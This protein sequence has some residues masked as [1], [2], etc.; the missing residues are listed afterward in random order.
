MSR[1]LSY[2]CASICALHL[3]CLTAEEL[4]I[5]QEI[6]PTESAIDLPM[7]QAA[8]APLAKP[9]PVPEQ[10]AVVVAE[11]PVAQVKPAAP[12]RP[13]TGKVKGKKVRLRL[14][15]DLESS[16]VKELNKS[17]LISVV[18]E[19]GN[20]WA[21]EPPA[22]VKAYVFRSFVLDNV[23]EGNR[24]NVRLE[25]SLDAPV[26]SHLSS[27]DKVQGAVSS[28]NNKWLEIK[29]PSA[30]RFYVA[31]D[32]VQ[33]VGGPELKA[34]LDKKRT[35][36]SHLFESASHLAKTEMSRPFEEIDLDKIKHQF[37]VIISDYSDFPDFVD[38][39]K[40]AVNQLQETYLQRRI[41]FLE[42]K[43]QKTSQMEEQASIAE[44]A[45]AAAKEEMAIVT[46]KMRMWEPIEE[47]L[48]LSWA[49]VNENK[50]MDEFYSEAKLTAVPLTGIL[51]SYVT[52]VKNKPGDFILKDKELP[53]AYLYS[54]HVNLHNL[55]GKKVTLVASPRPNN[56][57]AFPAYVVLGVESKSK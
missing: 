32:L 14:N 34:Q 36:V 54:T 12:F 28:L 57:F 16:V 4:T 23:V 22:D 11:K 52:P 3:T 15:A 41:A 8:P 7:P 26:I 45:A 6:I 55:V 51:E 24:V 17:D 47:A 25:P 53:V 33:S 44:A 38:K 13:F 56:N 18:G 9:S 19:T 46:D 2:F 5:P 30:T 48:Y 27:G 21:V 29:L 35:T 1:A 31:K 49:S 50:N 39:S 40:E 37:K 42:E 43:A 10:K 20:F